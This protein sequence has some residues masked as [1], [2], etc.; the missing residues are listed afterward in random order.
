MEKSS[1]QRDPVTSIVSLDAAL[2]P[3]IVFSDD[4]GRHP[5]SCQHLISRLLSR[6]QVTWVNTI[7]TRP[8]RLNWSTLKRGVEK[9]RQ[10]TGFS[11]DSKLEVKGSSSSSQDGP[12][13]P[14]PLILNP[15]MWPSFRSSF[16]RGL[17]RRLLT[18]SLKPIAET[19]SSAPVV[20]TTL[21]LMADVVGQFRA[22]RWVYYCVDDFSVW[23]GLDG[24]TMLNMESELVAK[25]DVA[26]A[27]SETLQTH[28]KKLGKSAHLL[29]HGVDLD[30]WRTAPDETKKPSWLDQ[31]EKLGGPLI[32]FWGVVDRRLD[33]EFVKALGETLTDGVILFVGPQDNPE[34]E[35]FQIPRVKFFPALPY[36]DLPYLAARTTVF[37]APYADL[38]VT[39][40][41]QPLKLKE[42]IATGKP[43]VVRKL[44]ATESWSDCAD[45]ADTAA[46]FAAAVLERLKSG[47]PVEQRLAR[48]RLE[49]EGWD[50]KAETFER[51]IEGNE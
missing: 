37:I 15:R 13:S 44:P 47:V 43:V 5:S 36:E 9:I 4:W 49:A 17:N 16:A 29:T 42:Y 24:R 27:V 1:I 46:A 30:F 25:V 18:R 28:L 38:P 51:W 48:K 21:P 8:P 7:G 2:A 26:I 20:I 35:L 45:V 12:N 10:W 32:V 23:P 39:R 19:G 40:A 3:L 31:L 22:V 34:P 41:M 33:L 6:R 14:N 11:S 50:A